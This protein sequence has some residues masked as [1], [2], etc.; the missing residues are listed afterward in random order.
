MIK[1]AKE[2]V[3]RHNPLERWRRSLAEVLLDRMIARANV[4]GTKKFEAGWTTDIGDIH[5]AA[6]VDLSVEELPEVD[7]DRIRVTWTKHWDLFHDREETV[8][9]ICRKGGVIQSLEGIM[10]KFDDAN[11][12]TPLWS[13]PAV[14]P[15]RDLKFL[16]S[17][18]P[19]LRPR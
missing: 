6:V 14:P 5:W 13:R 3:Q 4:E 9:S 12:Q 19:L 17:N 8:Y 18:M 2:A 15:I 7:G 10:T 1:E 16:V 11:P